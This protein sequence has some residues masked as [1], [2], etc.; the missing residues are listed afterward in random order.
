MR[1]A[2]K[3]TINPTFVHLPQIKIKQTLQNY[4]SAQNKTWQQH[5]V[6]Q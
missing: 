6:K 4:F 5:T 3:P 2:K 1:L